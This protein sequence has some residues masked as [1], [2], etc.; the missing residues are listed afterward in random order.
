M[1]LDPAGLINVNKPTGVSSFWIVKQIRHVLGVK[2]VGHCGTLDPLAVGVLLVVFGKATRMQAACMASRKVYRTRLLLGVRTDTGD[3][4]GTVLERRT[5]GAL[6]DDAV[7]AVL[8]AFT[9]SIEQVP[10]MY[11]A[12]KVGGRRLYAIAREGKVIE[13]QPRPVRIYSIELLH[14]NETTIELRVECSPG[15][16]IR[17]LGEDIGSRLGCGATVEYLCREKVGDFDIADSIDGNAVR[18]L[19]RDML[20]SKALTLECLQERYAV[21]VKGEELP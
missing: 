12:L 3:I 21:P 5:V 17:T 7:R 15:T 4:T 20:L 13:R 18:E 14:R 11:S 19:G 16:Y 9:G 1:S 2:K 8:P 10:P 6:T